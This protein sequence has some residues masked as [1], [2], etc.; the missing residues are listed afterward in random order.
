MYSGIHIS[1][2]FFTGIAERIPGYSKGVTSR[3]FFFSVSGP[4]ARLA[5]L[6]LWGLKVWCFSGLRLCAAIEKFVSLR[7]TI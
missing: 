4:L 7:P 1:Q 2:A 3:A 5:T 6:F